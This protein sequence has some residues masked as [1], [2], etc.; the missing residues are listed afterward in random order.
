[1]DYLF[2]GILGFVIAIVLIR[3]LSNIDL[4][5][6]EEKEEALFWIKNGPS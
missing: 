2:V 5:T 1:M 6:K 3:W 4:R